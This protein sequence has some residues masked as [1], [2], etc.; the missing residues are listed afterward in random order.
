M[1]GVVSN[2][3]TQHGDTDNPAIPLAAADG[4][5]RILTIWAHDGRD[6]A[7]SQ[8]TPR[9]ASVRK[10]QG[11]RKSMKPPTTGQIDQLGATPCKMFVC[12][13]S[14]KTHAGRPQTPGL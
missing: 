10:V 11:N 12:E 9:Q 8:D 7:Q 13:E 1:V 2:S 5:V 14:K 3:Y 4:M 6:D